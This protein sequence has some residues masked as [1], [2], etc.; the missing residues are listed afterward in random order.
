[1]IFFWLTLVDILYLEFLSQEAVVHRCFV[2]RVFLKTSQNSQENTS[3]RVSF[4]LRPEILLKKRIWH[5]CFPRNFAKFLRTTSPTEHLRW[6]LL[7]LTM[8]KKY[9]M[10]M[11]SNFTGNQSWNKSKHF[12]LFLA[13]VLKKSEFLNVKLILFM[14]NFYKHVFRS[15]RLQMFFKISALKIFAILTIKKRLQQRCFCVRSCHMMLTY[16]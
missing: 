15:S 5:R 4:F 6:L 9:C 7:F 14:N 1:M 10:W 11:N 3:L 13:L 8:P 12:H 16:W 2:K